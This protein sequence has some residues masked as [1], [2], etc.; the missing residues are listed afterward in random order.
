MKCNIR[1]IAR[2]FKSP[3]RTS[4]TS[5]VFFLCK[6]YSGPVHF[7]GKTISCLPKLVI[8]IFCVSLAYKKR[9]LRIHSNQ[10]RTIRTSGNQAD[11]LGS[12]TPIPLMTSSI[13][14]KWKLCCRSRKQN[15]KNNPIIVLDSGL[16]DWLVFLL[17]IWT[18]KMNE[19]MNACVFIYRTYHILLSQGGLQFYWVR[20]N[21][22]LVFTG[23]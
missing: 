1:K 21:V 23:S 17:L 2:I 7:N 15:R 16:C 19:W 9:V 20:S 18:P 13:T 3:T 6:Q 5:I 8:R 4:S 12:R 22:S 14:S 10:N 11:A